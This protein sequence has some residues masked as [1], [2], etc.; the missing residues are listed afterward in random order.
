MPSIASEWFRANYGTEPQSFVE[1]ATLGRTDLAARSHVSAGQPYNLNPQQG[2]ITQYA[3]DVIETW[4][5]ANEARIKAAE[6]L[7]NATQVRA[8]QTLTQ[9]RI[10]VAAQRAAVRKQVRQAMDSVTYDWSPTNAPNAAQLK[11]AEDQANAKGVSPT[12]ITTDNV[13]QDLGRPLSSLDSFFT[14]QFATKSEPI[15]GSPRSREEF[16]LDTG[17]R[18]GTKTTRT[19]IVAHPLY[20]DGSAEAMRYAFSKKLSQKDIESWQG[21]FVRAGVVKPGAF[22]FGVWDNTTQQAMYKLMGEA[23]S[24]GQDVKQVRA[25]LEH[26]W[27]Q[28]GGTPAQGFGSSGGGSG[29]VNT[30]QRIFNI[31]SLAKGSELLRSYLQQELGRDPSKAEIASYVRLLNGQERKNPTIVS[32]TYSGGGKASITTTKEANVDPQNTAHDYVGG[33]MA[34]ELEARKTMEY[35]TALSEM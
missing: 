17:Q 26:A 35:M 25:G 23:N 4:R 2:V 6:A 18:L 24:I 8:A 29:P 31:T 14:G 5:Q 15:Y 33:S 28:M 1:K 30:T 21:F 22:Q 9:R 10:Q 11:A 16:M 32:T 19:A 20:R 12:F 13:K 7:S 3:P 27:S 34:K